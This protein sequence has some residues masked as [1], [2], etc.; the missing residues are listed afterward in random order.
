ME[1]W[2]LRAWIGHRVYAMRGRVWVSPSRWGT[3]CKNF[4]NVRCSVVKSGVLFFL[5]LVLWDKPFYCLFYL[6]T[7]YLDT[8]NISIF[9]T[10]LQ[11]LDAARLIYWRCILHSSLHYITRV[12]PAGEICE[13]IYAKYVREYMQNMQESPKPL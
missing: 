4:F 3:S 6:H 1:N 13:R 8:Y 12:P 5:F 7:Q 11:W 9:G 10:L 2:T